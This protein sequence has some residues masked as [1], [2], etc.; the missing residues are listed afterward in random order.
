MTSCPRRVRDWATEL[1]NLP[2]PMTTTLSPL[3]K[4]NRSENNNLANN[5]MFLWIAVGHSVLAEG[6]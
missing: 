2:N 1:P 6:K 4:E 5:W 3:E